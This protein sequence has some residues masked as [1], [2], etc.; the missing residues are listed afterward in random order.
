MGETVLLIELRFLGGMIMATCST[1]A[2]EGTHVLVGAFGPEA[3]EIEEVVGEGSVLV[4][5][6]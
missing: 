6:R 5:R 2:G 3:H 1:L 4:S